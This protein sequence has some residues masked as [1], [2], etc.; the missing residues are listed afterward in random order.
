M[1]YHPEIHHRR[2]IRLENYDY[3]QTGGYFITI[4]THDKKCLFGKIKN[5]EMILNQFGKIAH[6]EWF[7]SVMKLRW[8]YLLSCPTTFMEL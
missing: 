4:C 7:K 6:N 8:I 5:G 2:S 3:P 1:K